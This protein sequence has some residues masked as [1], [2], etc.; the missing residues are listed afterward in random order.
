[1]GGRAAASCAAG[2]RGTLLSSTVIPF[3]CLEVLA[4]WHWNAKV[5]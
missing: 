2:V 1:M 3:D 5:S 4:T